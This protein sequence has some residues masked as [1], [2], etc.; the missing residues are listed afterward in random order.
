MRL[1]H[2]DTHQNHSLPKLGTENTPQ[3]MK[4]PNFTWSYHSGSGRE[5]IDGQLG[6]YLIPLVPITRT[7]TSREHTVNV[8]MSG[9]GALDPV[10]RVEWTCRNHVMGEHRAPR[11]VTWSH[12]T[13]KWTNMS[14]WSVRFVQFLIPPSQFQPIRVEPEE[15]PA[16]PGDAAF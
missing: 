12:A 3:W 13:R 10:T 1:K 14:C 5:S 15:N 2:V 7:N 8:P 11:R 9:G 6:S 4:I 16:L